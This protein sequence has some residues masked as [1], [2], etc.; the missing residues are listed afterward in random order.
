MNIRTWW[1]RQDHYPLAWATGA[2]CGLAAVTGDLRWL[3]MIPLALAF[4]LRRAAR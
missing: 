2:S 3:A 1:A 4:D